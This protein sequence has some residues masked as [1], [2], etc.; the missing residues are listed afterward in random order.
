MRKFTHALFFLF[1]TA[2]GLSATAGSPNKTNKNYYAAPSNPATALVFA[3]I[4]GDRANVQWTKGNGSRRIVIASKDSVVS[5]VPANGVAYTAHATFGSGSQLMAGQFVVYDGTGDRFDLFGLTTAHTYYVA[6]FEYNGSNFT[7]EY[8]TINPGRGNFNTVAA[9]LQPATAL[10]ATAIT[11][12]RMTLSWSGGN[13]GR[14]LVLARKGAPVNANPADMVSYASNLNFGG[15]TTINGDN[16]A[17]YSAAG[18]AEVFKNF[19]PGT[20]YHFAVFEFNGFWAPAYLTTGPARG[21]FTTAPR[22]TV[23]A[24]N[25]VLSGVEGNSMSVSATAGN[26]AGRIVVM[27]AGAPVQGLPVDGTVYM[28]STTFGSGGAFAPGEQVVYVGAN[29]SVNDIAA[30]VPGTTYHFAVFEYDGTGSNTRYLATGAP[31]ASRSTASAPTVQASNIVVSAITNNSATVSFTPGNGGSRL[32]IARE[33]SAVNVVPANL[34][35]YGGNGAF[36][37]NA[38]HASDN[39]ALGTVTDNFVS[40]TG[41]QPGKTYH[42]AVYENNGVFGRVYNTTAPAVASFTTA[43]TPTIASTNMAFPSPEGNSLNFNWTS[44]NGARRLVIA[45]AGSA[46]TTQP[47][48]GAVYTANDIFGQGQELAPGQFVAYNGAGSSFSLKGLATGTTYHITVFEYSLSGMAPYYLR[49][50]S[51]SGSKSTVSAPTVASTGFTAT[52]TSNTIRFNFTAGNGA[53]RLILSKANGPI[54]PTIT[55][56]TALHGGTTLPDGTQ[57][58]TNTS[59]NTWITYG[60]QPNQ[61][62]HFAVVEF[63]GFNAPVYQQLPLLQGSATTAARPTVE[64]TAGIFP[65]RDGD[66]LQLQWTSGNGIGRLIV[67]KKGSP[68]TA[69]PVDGTVYTAND[70]MGKGH[71]LAPGEF[72]V[73]STASF[74]QIVKGLDT[75]A[76]YH[77]AVFEFDG[78]GANRGYLTARVLRASASTVGSPTVQASSSISSNITATSATI[79]WTLGNGSGRLVVM[80]KGAPVTATPQ[81]FTNYPYNSSFGGYP[82]TAGEYIVYKDNQNSTVV[83]SMEPGT[84]YHVAVWEYNGYTSPVFMQASPARGTVTTLGPP[85]VHATALQF[86]EHGLTS[87]T[88]NWQA[89]SGQ[90]R[91]V[92]ARKNA[93]IEFVPAEKTGYTANSFFGSGQ[94]VGPDTYVVYNGNGSNVNVTALNRD[95]NYHFAVFEYNHFP[96]GEVYKTTGAPK[97]ILLAKPYLFDTTALLGMNASFTVQSA[98]PATAYQWQVKSGNAFINLADGGVYSGTRSATLRITGATADMHNRVSTLR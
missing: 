77:F 6:V 38:I 90:K 76:T 92:V 71:Q 3:S 89:G 55:D 88:L 40:V 35:T 98:Q 34:T 33:G 18:T 48:D 10:T 22:P 80:R 63:N 53:R 31:A 37:S 47:V 67:V 61:T 26:G 84:T 19:E 60:L 44:G 27:R 73:A 1:F 87:A 14:R 42:L 36:G 49:T 82:I 46:V 81:N 85:A 9:P 51:L 7:T 39:Y 4:D 64:P 66:R 93:A 74:Y 17:M 79:G 78:M 30:L 32:L 52:V 94:M 21:S 13:G 25:I 56:F 23:A 20:T 65:A 43:V 29:S 68:V 15:G 97:A 58:L 72:V 86:T 8:L 5:A 54:N 41:L 59:D 75:A 57:V 2:V 95:D 16:W 24:S 12:N 28:A 11:G 91:L 50:A 45:R 96:T 70:T 62:V 83:H 69:M